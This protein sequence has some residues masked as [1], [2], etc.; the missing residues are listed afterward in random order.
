MHLADTLAA[1][2][3]V[4]DFLHDLIIRC[5]DLIDIDDAGVMLADPA[6]RLHAVAAST[7]QVHLLELFEVQN[8]DGPCLDAYRTGEPVHASD[9]GEHAERWPTFA[10]E[11]IRVGFRSAHSIPMQLR[12]ETVGAI[13]LLSADVRPLTDNDNQLV[14]ALARIATIGLLQERRASAAASTATALQHALDSRVRIE[15]AKG[16]IAE[17]H[18]TSMDVAFETIRSYARRHQLGISLV[19]EQI[20]ARRLDLA[21]TDGGGP[22]GTREY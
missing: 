21:N 19:A 7:E 11:A 13:N 15:Q 12:N 8:H 14:L 2:Y 18:G 1:D 10:D 5:T 17:R 22:C 9:L 20:V 4:I 6:G 3:D 16:I